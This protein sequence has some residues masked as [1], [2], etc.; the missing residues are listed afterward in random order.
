MS[1][2]GVRLGDL[3][4][5]GLGYANLLYIA[6]VLVEL[7]SARQSELTLLLVEEPEAH[8]HPQL[9]RIVLEYLRTQ[10]AQSGNLAPGLPEGRIQVITTTHSPHLTAS[11]EFKH[12][13][14][15]KSIPWVV[16]SE[17]QGVASP[18]AV[19]TAE[20][21]PPPPPAEA[22]ETSVA[23]SL[24]ELKIPELAARKIDRY[25]D[26]TR[27]GLLFAPKVILLEGLA[28]ALLLPIFARQVL[29]TGDASLRRARFA[30]AAL[31]PIEGVD[32]D[33]YV[34]LL[35]TSVNGHCVSDRVVVITDG[36]PLQSGDRVTRL[37]TLAQALGASSRLKIAAAKNTLEADLF[38][39]GNEPAMRTAFLKL[40][41]QSSAKWDEAASAPN[42]GAA[43]VTLLEQSRVR[44]GDFAQELANLFKDGVTIQVPP[45][46]TDAIE[47]V[48]LP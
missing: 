2:E 42:A 23:I 24:A 8:L 47:A 38:E 46:L 48:V 9:Q 44:K 19:V 4:A 13:V 27:C 26:V 29:S 34:R 32:F 15:L 6:T 1:T 16:S 20:A 10:A 25:L 37:S 33:P 39:A 7:Q 18:E 30:S 28:E 36:D 3:A 40:R 5:S 45:Y 31:I 43:V 11:L 14:V 17:S 22:L 12:V 41:P 21:A 35:L